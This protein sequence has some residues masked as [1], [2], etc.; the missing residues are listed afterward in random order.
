MNP[1]QWMKG[2]ETGFGPAPWS[3]AVLQPP[4]VPISPFAVNSANLQSVALSG[5]TPFALPR[6]TLATMIFP[7][8]GTPRGYGMFDNANAEL[9]ANPQVKQEQEEASKGG[10]GGYALGEQ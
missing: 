10:T 9:A 8:F 4:P 3:S 6:P 2:P 7:A 1:P 5:G